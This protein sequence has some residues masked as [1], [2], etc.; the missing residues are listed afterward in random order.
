[1]IYIYWTNPVLVFIIVIN[2]TL[3]VLENLRDKG[4][5]VFVVE[6]DPLTMSKADFCIEV[7]PKA[8]RSGGNIVAATSRKRFVKGKT[9]TATYLRGDKGLQ[10][11]QQRR[12]LTKQLVLKGASG[13]NLK[14][15]QCIYSPSWIGCGYRCI[16]FW[17]ID[18]DS[19]YSL[20][21]RG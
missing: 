20:R 4:N 12:K 9:L 10:V 7:G 13:N 2:L 15:S 3:S 5:S 8:G 11:P 6:H 17:K 18:A 21:H 14:G 16:R 19:R 1:M